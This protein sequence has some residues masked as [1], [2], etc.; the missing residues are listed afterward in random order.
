MNLTTII[1]TFNEEAHLGRCIESVKPLATEILVVDSGSTD[2]TRAVALRHDVRFVEH[3]FIN[4][5]EQFNWAIEQVSPVADW[6]LRIDADEILTRPLQEELLKTLPAA[7]ADI[8]GVEVCRRMTFLG[9][10]IRHGGVFPLRL[11]RV[12][13]K[14]KGRSESRWMDEHIVVDGPCLR[15][16][17]EILDDNQKDLSWWTAKHNAYSSR[18]AVEVLNAEFGFLSQIHEKARG[19]RALKRK[20]W[21]KTNAYH[22]LPFG[23]RALFYFLYR[24]VIRL[25][26]LDG[27]EGAAFHVLQG[28]WYRFLVDCKV[29]E[30]KKRMQAGGIG[31]VAA[32]REVLGIDVS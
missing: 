18:E 23:I 28:F 19:T 17:G 8:A 21:L 7:R 4:Q 2:G 22:R 12:F 10:P 14:G 13:R 16:G 27:K 30:V 9:K 31:P 20:R 29:F 6:I 1:L 15:L 32:I 5:A 11:I 25:G 3:P 24:Y 26:F